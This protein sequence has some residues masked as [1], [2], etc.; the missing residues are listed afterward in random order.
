MATP[1][2]APPKPDYA[3]DA[4]PKG[5]HGRPKQPRTLK[6][7]LRR[8]RGTVSSVATKWGENRKAGTRKQDK[9]REQAKEILK[10]AKRKVDEEKKL[11]G[12][13]MKPVHAVIEAVRTGLDP[14]SGRT[15]PYVTSFM[16][17]SVASWVVGP[18][19][20]LAAYERIR[21]HTSTTSWGFLEGPGRWFRDT[22]R[23]ARETGQMSSL[24]WAIVIGLAP[25]LILNLRNMA[26]AH[27]ASGNYL[28]RSAELGIKWL[29]RS[30]HLVPV[31]YLTGIS[32]PKQTEWLFG[33]HWTLGWWQFW[34]MG[35][36]CTAWYFTMWVF[37]RIEKG[38][39]LGFFHALLM[40]PL[41]SIVTGFALDAPG[42]AW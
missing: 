10:P 27:V 19:I 30:A 22:V 38:L 33:A 8:I 34:V 24:I 18:Q 20:F 37:D 12:E 16:I 3:P 40:V 1:I 11:A 26:A 31:L 35:L 5:R 17:S 25:M 32:Y 36:A 7:D 15:R 6:G 21:F 2:K 14:E 23:M 29:T 4:L 41:A 13:V 42:A 28:G 9:V 39:G